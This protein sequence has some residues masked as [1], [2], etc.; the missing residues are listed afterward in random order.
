MPLYRAKVRVTFTASFPILADCEGDVWGSIGK[1]MCEDIFGK[2]YAN[3]DMRAVCIE[4]VSEMEMT[5]ALAES[6]WEEYIDRRRP[7]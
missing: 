2:E 6:V 1:A 7:N 5:D 4:E 3:L